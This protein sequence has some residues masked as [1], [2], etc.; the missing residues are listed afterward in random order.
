MA[1]L[2]RV[3]LALTLCL[4]AAILGGTPANA[5]TVVPTPFF[6]G[7]NR[8]EALAFDAAGNLY[9]AAR[10]TSPSPI[11]RIFKITKGGVSSTVAT[12]AN[13]PQGLAF[14]AAGNLYF[15][16]GDYISRV[17]PGGTVSTFSDGTTTSTGYFG[18]SD[19]VFGSGGSLY[20]ADLQFA[21][22]D[23]TGNT[24]LLRKVAPDGTT[25]TDVAGFPQPSDVARD[26]AGNIYVSD[27]IDSTIRKVTPTG[28]VSLFADLSAYGQP[29]GL[30]L[31]IDSS[32]T[33]YAVV[34]GAGILKITQVGGITTLVAAADA[35]YAVKLAF[36]A[37][38]DLYISNGILGTITR[39][40]GAGPPAAVTAVP[41]LSEWALILFG[42]MLA[43]GAA[44]FIHRRR[45]TV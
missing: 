3:G 24:R 1:S 20:V 5:Q 16:D 30:G 44:L 13:N 45:R 19:L 42:L 33:V 12:P 10:V 11:W 36:N 34:N 41:T 22:A 35:P 4:G 8:P 9:V 38:G 26:S 31:A 27:V 43:S 25:V 40:I 6:S 21:P 2:L 32:D 17:S 18:V 23:P 28:T 15:G 29:L 37:E 7:L 14:D 39:V